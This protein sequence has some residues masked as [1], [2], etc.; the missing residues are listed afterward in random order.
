MELDYLIQNSVQQS[1]LSELYSIIP[2]NIYGKPL[3]WGRI[4]PN[5]QNF[6]YFPHQKNALNKFTLSTTKVSFVAVAIV[7]VSFFFNFRLYVHM[8]YAS[9]IDRC[10]LNVVFSMTKAL[11]GQSSPEKKLYSPHLSVLLFRAPFFYF[12][13]Y[14]IAT[15][16]TP[17]GT[18]WLVN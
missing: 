1:Y 9:F 13:L 7:V 2:L 14:K 15:D 3:G 11:N 6:T 18:L 10:L 12:E 5:S 4:P 17:N 16:S 8:C